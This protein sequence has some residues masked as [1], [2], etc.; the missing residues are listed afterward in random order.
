ME[1]EDI[2]SGLGVIIIAILSIIGRVG[3]AKKQRNESKEGAEKSI[4]REFIEKIED[5]EQ[6]HPDSAEVIVDEISQTQ[7]QEQDRIQTN[8]KN[9]H[10]SG[11][12]KNAT[13]RT[14]QQIDKKEDMKVQHQQPAKKFN[15]REAVIYSEILTPKF[16]EQ[17]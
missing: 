14:F 9:I 12:C 3:N 1:F 16:K 11:S 7:A 8:N 5:M 2:L 15:L 4:L 13:N 17:E 6:Q 10:N